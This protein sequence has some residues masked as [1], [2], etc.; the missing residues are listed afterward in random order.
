M[1]IS[2]RLW[3]ISFRLEEARETHAAQGHYLREA[4]T[5]ITLALLRIG[6]LA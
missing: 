1:N 3:L 5:C 6:R 2:R 4:W